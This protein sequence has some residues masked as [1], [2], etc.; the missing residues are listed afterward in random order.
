MKLTG[1][2]YEGYCIDAPVILGNFIESI[3]LVEQKSFIS[4]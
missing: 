4:A 3:E 1:D 2:I